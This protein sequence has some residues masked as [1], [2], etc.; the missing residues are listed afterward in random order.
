MYLQS[1]PP[2]SVESHE[3][4]DIKGLLAGGGDHYTDIDVNAESRSGDAFQTPSSRRQ[5]RLRELVIRG[6]I[7]LLCVAAG[8]GMGCW[9]TSLKMNQQANIVSHSLTQRT[10]IPKHVFTNRKDVPFIPNKEFMGPGEE[11]DRNWGKI[12]RGKFSHSLTLHCQNTHRTERLTSEKQA[13]TPSTSPTHQNTPKSTKGSAPPSSSSMTRQKPPSRCPTSTT[14][15][16]ST[17]C[18]SCTA[19]TRPGRGT[20]TLC[21]TTRPRY[22]ENRSTRTGSSTSSTASST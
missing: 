4:D 22:R 10:P 3:G 21:T 5:Q 2:N 19:S 1:K 18:T 15:T 20:T 11:A 6:T 14:S 9:F 8:A 12:V 13:Q 17:P 7:G 16:S